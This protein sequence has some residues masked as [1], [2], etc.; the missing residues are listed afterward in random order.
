MSSPTSTPTFRGATLRQ[1]AADP[2]WLLWAVGALALASVGLGF[3]VGSPTWLPV[4]LL[5]LAAA[6]AGLALSGST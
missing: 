1:W 4:L 2:L 6:S 3:A 5:V